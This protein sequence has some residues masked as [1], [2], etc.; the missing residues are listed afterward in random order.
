[1]SHG[2][3]VAGTDGAAPAVKSSAGRYTLDNNND[4]TVDFVKL[5]FTE[6][7][8]DS[9]VAGTDFCVY[10]VAGACLASGYAESFTSLTPNSGNETDTANDATVYIGI[11]EVGSDIDPNKTDYQMYIQVSGTVTD[12][13]P[14]T[15]SAEGATTQSTDGAA[16]VI[17]SSS[18]GNTQ[19][20]NVNRLV[21][22]FSEQV[23][24]TDASALDGFDALNLINETSGSCTIDTADVTDPNITSKT[25]NVTCTTANNTAVLFDPQ[26]ATAGS[27]TIIDEASNEMRNAE[28]VTATDNAE[29]YPISLTYKDVVSVDGMIDRVDIVFSEPIIL[30]AYGMADWVFST[31][32][33]ANLDDTG[34]SVSTS[35]LLL[36]VSADAN[37]TG[38]ATPPILRY[39]NGNNALHDAA[40][41]VTESFNSP[42]YTVS[43]GAAPRPKTVT[44][45]DASSSDR[46]LDIITVV[47]TEN[48]SAVVNGAADWAVSSAANFSSLVEGTVECN[49]GS[50]G[51]NEC[52]YN[53]T[54][55]TIKTNVGDLTLTYT[56][57]TS[58][59]D[60]TNTAATIALSSGSMPAFTDA[61]APAAIDS[62]ISIAGASGT[63]GAFKI[64][65]TVTVTWNNSSTAGD[66]SSVTANLSQFGGGASVTMTDTTACSGTASNNIY[67]ACYTILGSEGIDTTNR[68]ASVSATDAATNNRVGTDTSNATVDTIVPTVTVGNITVTG[69]SGTS[70]AF[71][72]ADTAVGRWDNSGTGDNNTD[73]IASVT[74]N[75]S[76]F[77][78]G[79]SSLSGL[80]ASGI[81][82]A[83]V[84]T[85]DSLDDTNNNIT[86]TAVDNAGNS[87]ATADT[88]NYTVDTIVPV[89]IQA[90]ITVAGA[91]GT[92]GAFKNS[93]SPVLTWNPSTSG[94]SDTI[95]SATFNGASFKSG[96]TLRAGS[97]ATNWTVS[98]SGAMDSQDDTGN[99]ITVTVVDNAG[100]STGPTTSSTSY[101]IDTTIPTVMSITYKDVT[102]EDGTVDRVDVLFSEDMSTGFVAD[103]NEWTFPTAGTVTLTAPSLDASVT[104]STTTVRI[105]PASAAANTTGGATSPTLSYTDTTGT[106]VDDAG[107]APANFTA[108]TVADGAAPRVK[109]SAS[110]YTLD[111]N[112]NGT[113]DYVKLVFTES[114][115]DSSVAAGD[116]CVSTSS[117]AC[118]AGD[119]TEAFTSTTPSSGNETDTAN[120]ATIYVGV[121]AGTQSITTNKTDYT[122]AVQVIGTVTDATPNTSSAEGS[123]TNSTDGAAPVA[124]SASYKDVTSVNG[125]VD[126]VDVL[127]TET[128]TL[129]SYNASDWSFPVTSELTL[130]DTGASVS[131]STL[132]LTVSA[133]ANETGHSTAP[134]LRYTNN[135]N[136]LS[137]G[138][139]NTATFAS[140]IT[141]TDAAGPFLISSSPAD[142]DQGV[143]ANAAI[144][145]TFTEG[146]NTSTFDYSCCGTALD[147]GGRATAW[148]VSNTVATISHNNFAGSSQVTI[149][150]TTASDGTGNT[151]QGALTGAAD[152]FTFTVLSAGDRAYRTEDGTTRV[153]T[154]TILSPNGGEILTGG[155][156]ATITWSATA[157][158]LASI[159]LSYA[160]NPRTY[161]EI[162]SG[163]ANDGSYEWTVPNVATTTVRVKVSAMNSDGQEL[164][165]DTSNGVFTITASSTSGADGGNGELDIEEDGPPLDMTTP[166]GVVVT[167]SEGSLFRGVTFSDVYV[168]KDGTRYVFP[169][170]S[171]YFSYYDSFDDVVTVNDDQL[172]KLSLGQRMTMAPGR[173]IK[174]QSDNRVFQTQKNGAIRHVPD[175][176]TARALYG[177]IWA[178][179]I[180]DISVVFWGDYTVKE[181]LATL[182]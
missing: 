171:V 169:S 19:G 58:V 70:G 165:S 80:V 60:G 50:A 16:P 39:I 122:L 90:S 128:I 144:T 15:S 89:V 88:S 5:V 127:F 84:G 53:F 36:T 34:A 2:T 71:K 143:Q 1:M 108:Q 66:V 61:A 126:R 136:R 152:P 96:D 79:S 23:D 117:G 51:A 112:S 103:K 180:T 106:L 33:E 179:Q 65:D 113:V 18:T 20:P 31:A 42:Y 107:N 25:F 172:R 166:D 124:I 32:S 151:F 175:E 150:I 163:E 111:N 57:G 72:N 114:L 121:S 47:Y 177:S 87:T 56:A 48:I 158:G 135:G 168:V 64:S 162:A 26:Y 148:T 11:T 145:L 132:L 167:L 119:L 52:D 6:S 176:A 95:A 174:I 101:T 102:V 3:T 22:N 59:T 109:S 133:D 134:T 13:V 21:V 131:T 98:L 12:A 68:N 77:D 120:D 118:I 141:V 49:S 155:T 157:S 139:N 181:A 28:T 44:F 105:V 99:T 43:D 130:A 142:A 62:L 17:A 159:T 82:T 24:I 110:R 4:G 7:V 164:V 8:L 76:A 75:A 93:D 27:S 156:T 55:S 146:I 147:P 123:A 86:V 69:A 78:D 94:E 38:T 45:Y 154:A 9:S 81:Y 67:E 178:Q 125:A 30:N 54:T 138:T 74:I 137:D 104:V 14:N 182:R 29:P 100:N 63:G 170:E 161:I 37:E 129:S 173:M 46:K 85:L 73:T 153:I 116:F 92:G 160:T 97:L 115:L 41:A 10:D 149:N 91:T 140:D 40:G 35:T 83:T